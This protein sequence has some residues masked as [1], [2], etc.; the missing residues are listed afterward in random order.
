MAVGDV[1]N[2][3]IGGGAATNFQPAVGVEILLTDSFNVGF[4]GTGAFAL[5]NG[6]IGAGMNST[7]PNRTLKMFINNT[8][9]LY[10]IGAGNPVKG[11]CGIQTK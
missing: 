10:I 6:T 8:N 5:Y 11:Y 1:I 7:A 3:L 2:G 4:G 9:Y